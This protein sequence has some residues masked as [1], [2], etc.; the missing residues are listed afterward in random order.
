MDT[1]AI[2]LTA[3]QAGFQFPEQHIRLDRATVQAYLAAIGETDRIF[4]AA[5]G[6]VPPTAIMALSMRGLAALLAARPGTLHM[7]QRIAS[8]AMVPI[9]SEVRARL[10][11][12]NRSERRGFAA[13]SL[14]VE[15]VLEGVLAQEG[16][17][18]L[19]VPLIGKG[20]S[21]G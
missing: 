21:G 7:S 14:S 9:G 12:K 11:V 18:L 3:L 8:R 2:D 16:T 20:E 19:M 13:L 15:V 5:D 4:T 1:R 10:A 17:I 6:V